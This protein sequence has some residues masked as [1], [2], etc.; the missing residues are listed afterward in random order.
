MRKT[1]FNC[2]FNQYVLFLILTFEIYIFIFLIICCLGIW[3]LRLITGMMQLNVKE[4][5]CIV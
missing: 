4:L 5:Y 2:I 1:L 3:I